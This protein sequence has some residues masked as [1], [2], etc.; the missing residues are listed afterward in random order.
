V[1]PRPVPPAPLRVAL[2]AVVAGIVL[3]GVASAVAIVMKWRY[4]AAHPS[5]DWRT[6]PDTDAFILTVLLGVA[7]LLAAAVTALAG[8]LAAQRQRPGQVV[9]TVMLGIFT[10][11]ACWNPLPRWGGFG[12]ALDLLLFA[13]AVVALVLLWLPGTRRFYGAG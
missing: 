12:V 10:V 5:D 9:L 7:W 1:I 3:S 2:Y 8:A 11:A 4:A 6:D 13:L